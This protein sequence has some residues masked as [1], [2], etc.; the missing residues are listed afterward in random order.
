MTKGVIVG[1]IIL[2]MVP[3]EGGVQ[4]EVKVWHGKSLW[5]NLTRYGNLVESKDRH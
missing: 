4:V 1:W 2:S 5:T 3:E